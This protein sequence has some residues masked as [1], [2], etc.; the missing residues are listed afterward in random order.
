MKEHINDHVKLPAFGLSDHATVELQPLA[1]CNQPTAKHFILFFSVRD[2]P[3]TNKIAMRL[4]LEKID[5]LESCEEM[6]QILEEAI[7]FGMDTII[8]L[9]RKTVVANE[10]PWVNTQLKYFVRRLQ[11]A[12]ASSS[13]LDSR[14]LR[15]T[16][17]RERKACREKYYEAKKVKRLSGISKAVRVDPVFDLKHLTGVEGEVAKDSKLLANFIND[18]FLSPMSVFTPL[19]RESPAHAYTHLAESEPTTITEHSFITKLSALNAKKASGPD[20]IPAWLLKDNADLIAAPVAAIF[21]S[22]FRECQLPKSC[23]RADI[24]PLSK[25]TPILDVNKHLRPISLIPILSKV[26]EKYVKPAV[27]KKID[28]NQFGTVSN[29][30]TTHSLITMLHNWYKNTDGNGSTVHVVLF[31][32]KKAFDLIDHRI[33]LGKIEEYDLPVWTIK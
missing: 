18:S 14:M 10:A 9:P 27:L 31:H 28:P 15:N 26:A 2:T 25:Q 13:M 22:S 7:T 30:C 5:V 6:T 3:L 29:S 21:N 4:Y 32:F 8:P 33:L 16:V 24:T 1:C 12:L 17:N 20:S 11:K 19:S 23:K